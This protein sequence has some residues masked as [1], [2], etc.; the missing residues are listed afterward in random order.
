L[1][2]INRSVVF[3]A[4][5]AVSSWRLTNAPPKKPRL[6]SFPLFSGVVSIGAGLVRHL[7]EEAHQVVRVTDLFLNRRVGTNHLL[8]LVKNADDNA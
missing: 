2:R 7:D 5:S 1:F 4:K 3:D 6:I 8:G